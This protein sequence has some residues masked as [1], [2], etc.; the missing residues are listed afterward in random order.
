MIGIVT[1]HPEPMYIGGAQVPSYAFH[2][3]CEEIG[4]DSCVI[5]YDDVNKMNECDWVFFGTPGRMN[6]IGEYVFPLERLSVPFA[7]MIHAEFDKD[8]YSQ[9]GE[10]LSHPLRRCVVTIDTDYWNLEKKFYWHPCTLPSYLLKEEHE[11]D[12]SNRYGILYAARVSS[13]KGINKLSALSLFKDFNESVDYRIDVYG[14]KTSDFQVE[15][16][17][18]NW[19]KKAFSIYDE[20]ETER[21]NSQYKYFWDVCGTPSY[22]MPIKRLNL[23]AVEAIRYGCIPIGDHETI[24]P[25]ARKFCISLESGFPKDFYSS[26]QR[27]KEEVLKSPMSY[28]SVKSQVI[29]VIDFMETR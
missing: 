26:Q 21:R 5:R 6:S 13:W 11:F 14:E 7:V 24:Y 15:D 29:R 28:E 19:K 8:I 4:I 23:A 9:F 1:F 22:K 2:E 18:F 16:G 25:Y 3:W 27:M 17:N 10:F 20:L 12:N